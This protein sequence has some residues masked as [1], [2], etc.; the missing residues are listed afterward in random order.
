MVEIFR[1]YPEAIRTTEIIAERCAAFDSHVTCIT[2]FRITTHHP[3]TPDEHLARICHESFE[4]RY[5]GTPPERIQGSHAVHE[6]LRLIAKHDLAGFFLMYRDL[7]NLARMFLPRSV[8][9]RPQVHD[10]SCRQDEV[11]ARQ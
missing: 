5:E 6:E 11:G 4:Q 8:V 10:P 1:N 2:N 9:V 7:L 3:A